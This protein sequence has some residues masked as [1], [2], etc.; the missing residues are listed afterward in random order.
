LQLQEGSRLVLGV[1]ELARDLRHPPQLVCETLAVAGA[2]LR[3]VELP[4]RLWV[5]SCFP[6]EL[7][8]KTVDERDAL[9]N[10]RP[11]R[12]EP[13][14]FREGV[15]RGDQLLPD[16]CDP[17]QDHALERQERHSLPI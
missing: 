11:E 14:D 1:E 4:T 7:V 13:L 3:R 8:K 5:A 12:L 10:E 9:R 6:V 15:A 17:P 2:E 16:C